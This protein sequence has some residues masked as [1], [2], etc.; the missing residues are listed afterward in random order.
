MKAVSSRVVACM[1][2]SCAQYNKSQT[3]W[4]KPVGPQ[5]YSPTFY[6]WPALTCTTCGFEAVT[7]NEGEA[8]HAVD[9]R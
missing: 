5:W 3:V 8:T 9:D 1:N 7:V 2:K 6:D 4:A